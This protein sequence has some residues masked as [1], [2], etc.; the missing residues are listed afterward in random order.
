MGLVMPRLEVAEAIVTEAIVTD[1]MLTPI[2]MASLPAVE[3]FQAERIA[4]QPYITGSQI[5]ILV[6][7][8]T[9]VFHAVPSVIIGNKRYRYRGIFDNAHYC[10]TECYRLE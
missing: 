2:P 9:D 1:G 3:S 4:D 6:A 8:H 10:R 7:D 5:Y